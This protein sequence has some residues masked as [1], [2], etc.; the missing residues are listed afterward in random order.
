MRTRPAPR[1]TT[2][3]RRAPRD[4]KTTVNLQNL[5]V[6]LKMFPTKPFYITEYGYQTAPC[7]SFSQQYV[8]F[9]QQANYLK[10]AYAYAARF[11]QVK[12][13]MWFMLDDFSPSGRPDDLH[14]LLHR[15]PLA[16][17]WPRS[18]PGTRSSAGTS[19]TLWRRLLSRRRGEPPWS[20]RTA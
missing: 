16:S 15:P 11:R 3:R 6:L 5:P 12:L 1:R 8:S 17:I 14:G 2:G 13:L 20:P 19:L 7:Y 10:R 9:A 4:P 18:L